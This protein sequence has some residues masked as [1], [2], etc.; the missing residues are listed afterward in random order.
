MRVA[1]YALE[2][3]GAALLVYGIWRWSQPAAM[4]VAGALI[5][6]IA[7]GAERELL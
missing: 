4:V 6:V 7:I 5:V 1:L 2:V 3:I